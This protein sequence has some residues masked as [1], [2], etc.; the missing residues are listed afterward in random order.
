MFD[1]MI[2]GLTNSRTFSMPF[3]IEE[4]VHLRKETDQ[5]RVLSIKKAHYVSMFLIRLMSINIP[6]YRY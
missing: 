6:R 4:V 3:D 2:K 5:V 1:Q